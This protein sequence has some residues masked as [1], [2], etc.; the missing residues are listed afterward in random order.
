MLPEWRPTSKMQVQLQVWL[1]VT[2]L[3]FSQMIAYWMVIEYK[4]K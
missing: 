4:T 1:L 2:S 3:P